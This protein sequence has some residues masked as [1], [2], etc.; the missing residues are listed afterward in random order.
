MV[1]AAMHIFK[2]RLNG[3]VSRNGDFISRN[4]GIK[5]AETTRFGLPGMKRAQ[6][7]GAEK[8]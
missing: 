1:G 8:F 3:A 6:G 2:N 7:F 4:R 5:D